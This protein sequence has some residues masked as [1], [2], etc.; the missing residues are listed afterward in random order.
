MGREPP[1]TEP[2]RD[3]SFI[4][5]PRS[6]QCIPR[7]SWGEAGS[8]NAANYYFY[9]HQD[10]PFH[11]DYVFVPRGWRLKSVEVGAFQEWGQL[12]DHVPVVVDANIG[13]NKE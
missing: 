8:R 2:H 4:R 12:S 6:D 1:R 5:W 13:V 3:G 7:S 10:K 9:R 11:I